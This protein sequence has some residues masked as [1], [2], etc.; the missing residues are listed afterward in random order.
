MR[1]P[2]GSNG[3]SFADLSD[4]S[5]LRF[6]SH[7]VIAEHQRHVDLSRAQQLERLE[8]M[9]IGEADLQPGMVALE[10]GDRR[11]QQG[12]DSRRETGQPYPPGI[13]AD[14]GR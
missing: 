11:W 2:C 5:G 8:W 14:V 3:G 1:L 7:L 9:R 12:A 13:K 6:R 10:R 4:T